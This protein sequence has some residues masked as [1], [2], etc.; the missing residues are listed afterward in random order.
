MRKLK[1]AFILPIIQFFLAAIL[2]QLS[3]RAPRPPGAEYYVPTVWLICRG[4]NA[5]AQLLSALVP[6][7]WGPASEWLPNPVLGFYK[8][9]VFFLVGVIVVWYLVGRVLDRRRTQET[10]GRR[11]TFTALVAHPLLLATGGLLFFSGLHNLGTNRLN[12]PDPPW[13]AYLT[14]TWSVTLFFFPGRGL[15]KTVLHAFRGSMAKTP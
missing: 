3:Y 10:P 8:G 6:I 1:L 12:Y 13:D 9:D 11:R 14:L 7:T 15:A 4:L 2:V 5:P